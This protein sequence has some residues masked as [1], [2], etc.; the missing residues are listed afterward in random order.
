MCFN[1]FLI[2]NVRYLPLTDFALVHVPVDGVV[3]LHGWMHHG[4]QVVGEGVPGTV[5]QPLVARDVW[6]EE[7]L[8]IARVNMD[9]ALTSVL[10]QQ[11]GGRG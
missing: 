7:G 10:H 4:L 5:G 8:H 2:L 11:P 1:G 9:T 3:L 6:S